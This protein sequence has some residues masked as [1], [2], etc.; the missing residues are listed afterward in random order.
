[1]YEPSM[2]DDAV[3]DLSK[4]NDDLLADLQEG[5][6]DGGAAAAGEAA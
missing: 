5:P 2:G 6:P 4:V 3:S 1:M